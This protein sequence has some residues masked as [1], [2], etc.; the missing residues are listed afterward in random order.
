MNAVISGWFGVIVKIT[1]TQEAEPIFDVCAVDD[2]RIKE[3]HLLHSGASP[4]DVD[5]I[6][7]DIGPGHDAAVDHLTTGIDSC[8]PDA[9]AGEEYLPLTIDDGSAPEATTTRG[10][11]CMALT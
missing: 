3:S 1:H 10:C 5:G 6:P 9:A 2:R 8:F 11:S 7:D 4:H